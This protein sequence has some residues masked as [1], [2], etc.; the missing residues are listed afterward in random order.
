MTRCLVAVPIIALALGVLGCGSDGPDMAPAGG[1]VLYNSK[2]LAD[3]NVVFTPPTGRP[4]VG[5]TNSEGRF[6][7]T[8][9]DAHDGAV[10]GSHVVT[11]TK[12]EKVEIPPEGNQRPL[13]PDKIPTPKRL[14][15]AKYGNPRESGLSAQVAADAAANDFKFELTGELPGE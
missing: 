14:L 3:A 11:I 7:L 8:T 4:A 13:D 10:I 5:V 1:V 12:S 15:P 2:P 6:Q 9:V